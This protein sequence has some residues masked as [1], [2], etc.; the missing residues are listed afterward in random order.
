MRKSTDCEEAQRRW[1][2]TSQYQFTVTQGVTTE[3]ED[4]EVERIRESCPG[5]LFDR[6]FRAVTKYK[7]AEG[8]TLLLAD[9]LP[10]GAPRNLRA[11]F[12]RAFITKETAPRLRIEKV[13]ECITPTRS[14]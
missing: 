12:H 5:S 10:E 9:R 6:L 11:L 8:A 14:S 4:A 7:L 13:E 1:N 2:S 3:I